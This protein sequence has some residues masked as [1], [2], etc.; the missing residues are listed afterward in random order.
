MR[1]SKLISCKVP[2]PTLAAL[3]AHIAHEPAA[4]SPAVTNFDTSEQFVYS[5]LNFGPRQ[6]SGVTRHIL[7]FDDTH[8]HTHG[9]RPRARDRTKRTCTAINTASDGPHAE[10][11]TFVS[12]RGVRTQLWSAL[13]NKLCFSERADSKSN[14]LATRSALRF[15]T[16]FQPANCQYL[17]DQSLS[18]KPAAVDKQ[19]LCAC[20]DNANAQVSQSRASNCIRS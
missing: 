4:D 14:A 11:A 18:E 19:M 7:S 12:R 6:T 1:A 13:R 10:R 9:Q 8:T 5:S 15:P 17:C 2:R 3:N 20:S 16:N